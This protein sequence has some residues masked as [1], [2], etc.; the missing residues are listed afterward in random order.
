M[1]S[2]LCRTGRYVCTLA[3]VAL[4]A[5]GVTVREMGYVF[6]RTDSE[7]PERQRFVHSEM[8]M[9]WQWRYQ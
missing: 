2:K 5:H 3:H 4:E 8:A 7:P 6:Y 1:T 9:K